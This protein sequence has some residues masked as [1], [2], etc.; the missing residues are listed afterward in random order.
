MI[1]ITSGMVLARGFWGRISLAPWPAGVVLNYGQMRS[2][3]PLTFRDPAEDFTRNPADRAAPEPERLRKGVV[4]ETAIGVEVVVDRRTAQARGLGHLPHPQ[5]G[6]GRGRGV[7][8]GSSQ[9]RGNC[10]LA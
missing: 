5:N 4:V 2:T 9:R 3:R 1:R 6:A 8:G 10:R 7:H